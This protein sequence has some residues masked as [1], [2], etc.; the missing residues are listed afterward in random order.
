MARAI[1]F[2]AVPRG[3]A[4]RIVIAMGAIG[5]LI[6]AT[7]ATFSYHSTNEAIRGEIAVSLVTAA[8]AQARAASL[9]F[10]GR[11]QLVE[12]A[13]EDVLLQPS[14]QSPE[15]VFKHQ[16][17]L[18]S[19]T[20]VYY[21]DALTGAFHNYPHLRPLSPGY[22]PRNRPWFRKA[23]SEHRTVL[24]EP[25]RDDSLEE[26]VVTIA[27]PLIRGRTIVGVTGADFSIKS[28]VAMLEAD[29]P[30]GSQVFL[31]DRSGK[32]MVHSDK[33]VVGHP[34]A[35]LFDGDKPVLSEHLTEVTQS[36]HRR[37]V[38]FASIPGKAGEGWRIGLSLDENV[39]MAGLNRSVRFNAGF[40]AIEILASLLLIWLMLA[41]Y[42]LRPLNTII[43][44]MNG[45]VEG[46]NASLAPELK[47]RADEVGE[48]ARAFT[49][50]RADRARVEELTGAEVA[51]LGKEALAR[52]VMMANL[53]HSFGRVVNAAVAGDFSARVGRTFPDP[54]MNELARSIDDLVETMDTGLRETGEVLGA[55]ASTDLS[56]RVKGDYQGAFAKLQSATNTVADRLGE[57]LGELHRT[58]RQLKEATGSLRTE[59]SELSRRTVEETA[60][61]RTA[62]DAIDRLSK[63]VAENAS[64]AEVASERGRQ[65]ATSVISGQ[66][67]IAEARV[68]MEKMEASSSSISSVMNTIDGIA[69]RTSLLALN[70]SIEAARAGQAGLGFAVVASEVKA[71][72][73]RAADAS[74]EARMLIEQTRSELANGSV[75]MTEVTEN[76][77]SMHAAVEDNAARLDVIARANREQAASIGELNDRLHR[78]ERSTADNNS[79][80]GQLQ[81]TVD[82]TTI[83]A[84]ELDRIVET[85]TLNDV[86]GKMRAAA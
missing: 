7:A 64:H 73:N 17:L 26:D 22:D 85:F 42:L 30:H 9:W 45:L 78:I 11:R 10:E 21:G 50:F 60:S 20:G 28:L 58:S 79:L 34:V 46:S 32:I 40:S 8:R 75:M 67:V 61:L 15:D 49:V 71:L 74:R 63:V 69:S 16:T 51:R 4:G 52:K 24:T 76:L 12:S 59:A 13:N 38:T 19:F 65:A 27:T 5:S 68:A 3:I 29:K 81:N 62:S 77:E 53:Q 43:A 48:L 47:A 23:V 2:S 6:F 1:N 35:D 82:E 39:A 44:A 18:N 25:Y 83:R 86:T 55:I 37:F 31:V 36:G 80:A 72:A 54:E 84:G 33:R 66:H 57:I 56:R 41:R 14:G 70:A